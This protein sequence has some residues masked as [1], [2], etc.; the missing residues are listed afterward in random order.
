MSSAAPLLPVLQPRLADSDALLPYLRRI[1]ANRIYT[2]WGP[3]VTEF[4]R[5]LC[6]HL[7]LPTGGFVSASSGTAALVAAT[8]ATAGRATRERP[9]ALVPAFTFVATAVAVEQCGY[10]VHLA[11]VDEET[12]MLDPER[13][14][15]EVILD[16]VGVVMPVAPFG[17]PVPQAR[18]R[19]FR[20]RTGIPV[21]IDGA[22]S[23]E[24][25]SAAPDDQLDDI[26]VAMSFHA[27][28]SLSTGEGGGV[29]CRDVELVRRTAQALNF[30]FYD[31]RDSAT[32]ST[33]GKLSEYHAALG[34]AEL[35][36]W[37]RKESALRGVADVYRRVLADVGISD[38]LTASPEIC[39]SYV[40]FRCQ[41]SN[42]ATRVR[43]ALRRERVDHRVWYGSGLHHQTYFSECGRNSLDVTED[44]APRIIG[45]PVAV[46][47]SQHSIERV[48]AALAAGV[49]S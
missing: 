6:N 18:W 47:L 38:R 48:A 8:L 1:D 24:G 23:F 19:K 29:A 5:R 30:G 20:T 49:R 14:A 27:T 35:D 41:S 10:A 7:E 46:D 42:E 4:E 43:D 22:A 3:L 40:L 44:I 26:P 13:L 15:E 31:V 32:P 2:N 9:L 37:T 21:V 36:G 33:N 28:K 17:R 39:S 45:L 16:R 25:V 11:D 34:L 12:W